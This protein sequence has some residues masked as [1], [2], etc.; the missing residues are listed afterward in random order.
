MTENIGEI[1]QFGVSG[2]VWEGN[3]LD[4]RRMFFDFLKSARKSIVIS[5]FSLGAKNDDM[6]KFFEIIEEKLIEKIEVRFVV[7]DDNNL[8]Q[9]SREKLENFDI[10][11]YFPIENSSVRCVD[12]LQNNYS[13]WSWFQVYLYFHDRYGHFHCD[14]HQIQHHQCRS[15]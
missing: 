11:K 5:A 8:K 15:D 2:R 12:Y 13:V 9:F 6:K 4:I 3:A 7:N 14:P 1:L 10:E